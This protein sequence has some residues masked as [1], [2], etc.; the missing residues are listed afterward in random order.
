[1][2]KVVRASDGL[3]LSQTK[4]IHDLLHKFNFHNDKPAY[5]RLPSRT[6]LSLVD[7]DL[8]NDRS[9]YRNMVGALQYLT[10]ARPGISYAMNLVSQFMHA[11]HATHLSV[12]QRIFCYL[13][14]TAGYGL[15]HR[16]AKSLSPILTYSNADRVGCCDSSLS[17]IRYVVLSLIHI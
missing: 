2:G 13:Q 10:M 15:L 7:R 6:T 5:T 8:L 9:E 16:R 17:T 14:V 12:V 4:Y 11:P 1:M 3:F